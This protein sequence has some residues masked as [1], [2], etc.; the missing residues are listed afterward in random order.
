[1]FMKS[2]AKNLRMPLEG[3]LI[4]KIISTPAMKKA[5]EKEKK[6]SNI[7]VP[8]GVARSIE[9]TFAGKTLNEAKMFNDHP[10]IV[11]VIK[12]NPKSDFEEGDIGLVS[13]RK[14]G[15]ILDDLDS[16]FPASCDVIVVD[17]DN[18]AIFEEA[19]VVAI[20]NDL[21]ERIENGVLIEK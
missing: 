8:D 17:G 3:K 9:D 11:E 2:K 18:Y 12:A 13:V 5:K 16:D 6:K 14:A 10:F 20:N 1:M 19:F 4:V 21:K 15:R 7:I